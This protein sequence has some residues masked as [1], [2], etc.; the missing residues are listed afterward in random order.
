MKKVFHTQPEYRVSKD[1]CIMR[2]PIF[3]FTACP[4]TEGAVQREQEREDIQEHYPQSG[5][6]EHSPKGSRVGMMP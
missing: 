5:G 2:K 3:F 6:K 4:G 1:I